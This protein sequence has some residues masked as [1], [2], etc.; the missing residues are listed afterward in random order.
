MTTDRI[1]PPWTG[2]S[3]ALPSL[4]SVR[5][6]ELLNEML[7]RVGD[8]T[9][10]HDRLRSLL[11]AVV[12]IATDLD[13]SG[14][15]ERIVRVAC[16]LSDA[17]YGALGVLGPDRRLS[18]FITHGLTADER[19]RIGHLPEGHGILGLLI[20]SPEPVRMAVIAA[21]PDSYGFPPDHPMMSSFLGVPI[22]I[23]DR[24][25]G[26][27]YLTNKRAAAEFSQDDE[28]IVVALAAAA[29]V[30]IDNA[31]LY[32][33]GARRQRWLQAAT[34]IGDALLDDIAGDGA[35]QLV[36]ARAREVSQSTTALLALD[37]DDG[38]LEWSIV[39][40][41]PVGASVHMQ[42]TAIGTVLGDVLAKGEAVVV[43]DL[44]SVEGVALQLSA[45][46][47]GQGESGR[48]LA[49]P[50]RSTDSM[51]GV[52]VLLSRA[53]ERKPYTDEDIDVAQHFA[54]QAGL[55]VARVRA[56]EDRQ[57]LAVLGDRDRI[58]RDLHDV[59][60]QRLFATGLSLQTAARLAVRPDAIARVESAVDVIDG[61][62]RDIRAAIFELHRP[63]APIDF[64]AEL[65]D[66]LDDGAQQLGFA[67]TLV[68]DGP[69][70]ADVPTRVRSHTLAMIRET[71]SNAARHGHPRR[72]D[73]AVGYGPGGLRVSV[74]DDG[75]GMG[76]TARR[77]GLANL[78]RRADELGGSLDISAAQPH[79]TVVEW[80]VPL[81]IREPGFGD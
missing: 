19:A 60:I 36:T 29:G 30:A 43:D 59:V 25:F 46:L 16:E 65:R 80:N 44:A 26:N 62:I 12:G 4:S 31:R 42:L 81:G 55:A 20:K 41:A 23:R 18:E 17:Q 8:L 64:G 78:A 33:Q 57:L 35:L 2:P 34:E 5:L 53:G 69:L 28:D 52:L 56:R 50:V 39:D 76:D 67:P 47:D 10:M 11:D 27:L 32:E 58:A 68:L 66:V 48:M 73:V 14:M 70:D 38:R 63:V 40:G 79:G 77:S 9:T 54:A 22:R 49:V 7:D 51:L 13:L 72:V 45:G 21:H 74:T 1:P 75:S 3:S 61:V 24:V 71:V 37:R 15:L 6:D